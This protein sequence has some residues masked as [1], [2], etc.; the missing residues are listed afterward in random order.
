MQPKS[1]LNKMKK[2]RDS[3]GV[4]R[5]RDFSK[6]ILEYGTPLPK[7]VEYKDIDNAFEEWVK[8]K[9]DISY[10]GK[11]L[12]TFKLYSNQRINEYAQTWS[13]LDESGNLLMNFKTITRENNPKK[14][15]NQGD[16]YNIPGNRFYPMF[17]V[18]ILQENGNEAYDMY[19]MRQPFTV[20]FI[21]SV[22]IVTN[23]YEL[24]NDMNQ[25]VNFEFN[26]IESYIQPNGHYMSM[27]LEDISDESEYNLEDRKYYSQTYQI[28]VKAYIIREEDF[29][30][31]HL[32]S[33]I[34]LDFVGDRTKKVKE[35]S[36]VLE[37]E[38]EEISLFFNF[39][40]CENEQEIVIKSDMIIDNIVENQNVYDY[41]FIINEEQQEIDK[42]IRLYKDDIVK[43][44]IE[45]DNNRESSLLVFSGIKL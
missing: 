16:N 17:I 12:P 4:E 31:S 37:N 42:E 29:K 1:F 30:V 40:P 20:D 41:L 11:H 7:P 9:L 32:P 25:K 28:K 39:K 19:S 38:N 44:K 21:Y 33:R 24:L 18:P 6:M 2:R 13:H 5:R 10:N 8:T 27:V 14:G 35:I 45:K 26:A 22:S 23:K 34:I 3:Y 43:I 15:T 36:Y